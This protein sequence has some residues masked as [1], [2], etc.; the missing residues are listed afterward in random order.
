MEGNQIGNFKVLQKLGEG[1]MGVVFKGIDVQLE[2]PVAIKMLNPDLARNPEL[3]QR[4][5]AE[6]RAQANL[7]HANVATLYAFL[8]T[9]QGACM[10][11]EFVEG[12]S[13]EELIRRGGPMNP[14]D[15]VPLFKQALLGIG[16]AHRMGIVHRDIK[17]ANL[18]L[19]RQGIVKV[20]DFGIAKVMGTRGMTK[21]G[22]QMGTAFYMS[23]EQ[24]LNRGADI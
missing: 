3:V 21:T 2:R 15:A 9:E 14:R 16:A 23:P 1:G 19:N 13:F 22:T 24:V 5:Q 11:M 17:P 20:M 4:F 12:D 18:M 8:V 6:A 7:N 10:V